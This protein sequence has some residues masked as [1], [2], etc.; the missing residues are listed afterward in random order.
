MTT[1]GAAR[2]LCF[3]GVSIR[4]DLSD[5]PDWFVRG[6]WAAVCAFGAVEMLNAATWYAGSTLRAAVAAAIAAALSV[7]KTAALA[8]WRARQEA[9]SP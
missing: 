5:L 1:A 6:F 8:W 7:S 2:P 3:R 9:K 4:I